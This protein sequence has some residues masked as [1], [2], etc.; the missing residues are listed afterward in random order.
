MAETILSGETLVLAIAGGILPAL[1]WLWFW[2]RR[3]RENPEPTGLIALSFAA[4]MAVVYF[5]LPV[6]K[7]IVELLPAIMH[8]IDT[9]AASYDFVSPSTETVQI[10]LWAGAEEFG[11][12]ATVFLVAYHTRDFDEPMDAIIYLITAALGFVAMENILYL[13]KDFDQGGGIQVLINGNMRF[14]GATVL[15]TVSAAVLG[16]AFAF[17]FHSR[18]LIQFIAGFLGITIATLLHAYFNL[19][20][21]EAQGTIALLTVFAQF[22]A[23]IIGIIVLIEVVKRLKKPNQNPPTL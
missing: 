5:V 1:L 18:F 21:M 12:F 16:I 6:Q 10:I 15:H 17:A 3:D 8:G 4:G 7:L 22:W 11:K 20:I 19:S 2:L 9:L 23:V 14:I 13:I